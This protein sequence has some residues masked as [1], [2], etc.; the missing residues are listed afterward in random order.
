M[1]GLSKFTDPSFTLCLVFTLTL[2]LV[3]GRT[4]CN[5]SDG[6]HKQAFTARVDKTLHV[7]RINLSMALRRRNFS[8][9]IDSCLLDHEIKVT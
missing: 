1:R 5:K 8:R 3:G 4:R 7:V 6:L 2:Q 9:R